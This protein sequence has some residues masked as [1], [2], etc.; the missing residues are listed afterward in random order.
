MTVRSVQGRIILEGRCRV[1]DAE[2]LLSAL[3]QSPGNVVDMSMAETVHTAVV[4]VLLA[5]GPAI[6]GAH[7]HAF[8]ARHGVLDHLGGIADGRAPEQFR[9]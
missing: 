1:E 3:R 9:P 8:L 2:P 4:Q 5:A 7:K 6:V